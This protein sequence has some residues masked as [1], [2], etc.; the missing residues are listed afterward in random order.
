MTVNIPPTVLPTKKPN[1][2]RFRRPWNTDPSCVLN[3]MPEVNSTWRDYSGHG[4]DGTI[5]GATTIYNARFGEGLL[6]D[7]I[8]DQVNIPDDPSLN[9]TTKA[10][11]EAWFNISDITGNNHILV[12][13]NAAGNKRQYL[14]YVDDGV[15]K[16]NFGKTNGTGYDQITT[17]NIIANN[18]WYHT[19]ITYNAG[20]VVMYVDGINVK[21]GLLLAS[22]TIPVKDNPVTICSLGAEYFGGIIDEARI[23][24]RVLAAWE[25]RAL[26][27]QGRP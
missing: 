20:Y 27:E 11:L 23:Y 21:E 14:F 26:Y 9:P 8:N 18:T 19:A 6:F 2:Q 12:K 10:T 4:N 16:A 5:V 1:R 15:L 24:N 22:R 25:I 13:Y 17:A 7:G 3:L